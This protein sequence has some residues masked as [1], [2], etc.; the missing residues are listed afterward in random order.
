MLADKNFLVGVKMSFSSEVKEE[1][2]RQMSNDSIVELL[3][4]AAITSLPGK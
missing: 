3:K 1:L 2:S 4:L